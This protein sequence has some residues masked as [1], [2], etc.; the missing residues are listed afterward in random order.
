MDKEKEAADKIKA[1]DYEGAAQIYNDIIEERPND[2]I[3]YINFG[4]VL[5]Q[6]KDYTHAERFF[7]RAIELSPHTATAYFGLGNMYFEQSAYTKA[8][9]NFQKAMELGLDEADVYY[10]LG[11]TY[12]NQESYKRGLPY[13]QR[14]AELSPADAEIAFQYGLT[15]AQSG[16][17]AEANTVFEKVIGEHPEHSDAHYN[18]GVIALFK[19]EVQKALDHFNN[20]LAVQADHLLAA[21]G[22]KQAEKRMDE[23]KK[24]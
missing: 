9:E 16:Y 5:L 6:M 20:A 10:M 22:K 17:V 14:A 2:P 3:A 21:N 19:D 24:Q 13:L 11:M 4:N 7:R 12:Y 8:Q 18:L 15:L 23:I 1:N